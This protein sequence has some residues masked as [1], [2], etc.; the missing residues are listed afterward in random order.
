MYIIIII[1]DN[2]YIHYAMTCACVCV[3]VCLTTYASV[4]VYEKQFCGFN[5]AHGRK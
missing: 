5:H 2:N 1:V 4:Q 3:C